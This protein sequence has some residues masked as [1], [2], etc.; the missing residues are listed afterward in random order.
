MF[1][2]RWIQT[3]GI[4]PRSRGSDRFVWVKKNV[5][6][7]VFGTL[8]RCF[9]WEEF[10]GFTL[11]KMSNGCLNHLV[12]WILLYGCTVFGVFASYVPKWG[13]SMSNF[14]VEFPLNC[15][16]H[17]RFL[18]LDTPRIEEQPKQ[19]VFTCS[20]GG[21]ASDQDVTEMS[22]CA[23]KW[24]KD[25]VHS[26]LQEQFKVK[27]CKI[28]QMKDVSSKIKLKYSK[29]LRTISSEVWEFFQAMLQEKLDASILARLMA[30][31]RLEELKSLRPKNGE[32]CL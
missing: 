19:T 27:L 14:A 17:W 23:R 26:E 20:N 10:L 21:S 15:Y 3:H 30:E 16:K 18:D 2:V 7:A 5:F 1:F 11:R 24:I 22:W 8:G 31:E 12:T 4:D 13:G 32:R 6:V 9:R 25:K 28:H 29:G